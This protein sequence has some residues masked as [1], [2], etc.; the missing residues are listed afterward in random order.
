MSFGRLLSLLLISVCIIPFVVSQATATTPDDWLMYQHDAAHTGYSSN[1]INRPLTE[2][3]SYPVFGEGVAVNNGVVYL[4]SGTLT[5]DNRSL[6]V[7]DSSTGQLNWT[8]PMSSK[9]NNHAIT[10]A[11]ADGIVWTPSDSFNATTGKLNFN[12]SIYGGY[13]SPT[14]TNNVVLITANFKHPFGPD[15]LVALNAKTGT[16]LWEYREASGHLPGYENE[17]PAISGDLA[18]FS[19]AGGIYAFN[20]QNGNQVWHVP[21]YGLG[22]YTAAAYGNVYCLIFNMSS[23]KSNLYCLDASSGNINWVCDTGSGPFAIA[24]GIVYAHNNAVD[25]SSGKVVWNNTWLD[26]SPVVSGDAVYSTYSKR[27]SENGFRPWV[28]GITA[29]DRANGRV[30]WNYTISFSNSGG[31]DSIVIANG[32]LFISNGEYGSLIKLD[33]ALGTLQ[34]IPQNTTSQAFEIQLVAI[35][36]IALIIVVFLAVLAYKRRV[37]SG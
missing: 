12:Y 18:Y 27:N 26:Y 21:I 14:V 8:R 5:D 15:G 16:K 9:S 28:H 30:L 35:F 36:I 33:N 13:G 32:S 10:P 23:Y 1:A 19:C 22:G 37:K 11:I 20:V 25:A 29:I 34:Q 2:K 17:A 7:I 24:S 3:W 31:V 4:V 6:Y